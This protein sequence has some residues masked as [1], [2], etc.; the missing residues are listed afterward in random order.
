LIQKETGVVTSTIAVAE[1]RLHKISVEAQWRVKAG[2][3]CKVLALLSFFDLSQMRASGDRR[4][5]TSSGVTVI[6]GMAVAFA[7]PARYFCLTF[8]VD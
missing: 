3:F 8:G 6:T 4:D 2:R 5:R 7:G 1:K